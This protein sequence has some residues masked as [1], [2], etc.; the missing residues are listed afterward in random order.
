M[1]RKKTEVDTSKEASVEEC[2]AKC[3]SDITALKKEVAALKRVLAKK[4][5]SAGADPRVNKLIEAMNSASL[6]R[7]LEKVGL[8]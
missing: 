7:F 3:E 6:G 8:I 4:P 1:P 5:A 2:C